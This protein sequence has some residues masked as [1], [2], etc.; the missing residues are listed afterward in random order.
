LRI[1][2]TYFSEPIALALIIAAVIDLL[3]WRGVALVN[4]GFHKKDLKPPINAGFRHDRLL[5]TFGADRHM[6]V[7]LS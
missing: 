4:Y 3:V 2:P 5:V 1:C 7:P 6:L